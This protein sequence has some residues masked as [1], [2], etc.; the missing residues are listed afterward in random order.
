MF[1]HEALKNF[2]IET[3]MKI[4]CP[5]DH[6]ELA[7]DVL[8]SADLR[9]IDS[10]GVLKLPGYVRLWE[11][12]RINANPNIKIVHETPSTASVDGDSGLGLVVAP[13]VMNMA[14][15]K[16]KAVGSGWMSVK[17]SNHFGIAGYHAMMGLKHDMVGIAMTNVVPNMV[18]P[19]G[20]RPITGNN[21]I[22]VAVPTFGDFPFVLDISLSAV[23]GG[24]LILASKK[25]ETMNGSRKIINS[26][27]KNISSGLDGK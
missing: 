3:F 9:G 13:L 26:K 2:C 17:H 18:V 19:G 5:D 7:A 11:V 1:S 24:K 10:H 16:A 14:V 8:I 21:P 20:S 6:A 25:K 23:A 4:G 22:A 27:A 12:G 15:E